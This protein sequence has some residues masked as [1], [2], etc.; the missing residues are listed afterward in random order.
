M[1]NVFDGIEWTYS[2]GTAWWNFFGRKFRFPQ[3]Q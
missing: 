1:T 3:S 2:K